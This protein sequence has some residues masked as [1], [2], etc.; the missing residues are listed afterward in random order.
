[1][2]TKLAWK[3]NTGVLRQT[4][5]LTE[6]SAYAPQRLRWRK[7]KIDTIGLDTHGLLRQSSVQRN[8]VERDMED[9]LDQ[10]DGGWLSENG[11]D[12]ENSD[13]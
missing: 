13:D 1:M 8:L 12:D 5:N 4:D 3:L 2:S 9:Y 11:L 7:T 10:L 6:T